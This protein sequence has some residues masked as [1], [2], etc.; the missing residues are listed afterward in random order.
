MSNRIEN[1]V[2]DGAKIIWRNFAGKPDKYNPA[3]GKRQFNLVISPDDV[4]DLVDEGWN[5]KSREPKDGEGDTLYYLP[6]NVRYDG[7]RPPKIYLIT[8]R[9]KKKTMLDEDTVAS[10]DY[11]EIINCD[12]V[13]SPYNWKMGNRTGVTAY[14]QSMYVTIKEDEF[15]DKYG[16]YS[17]DEPEEVPFH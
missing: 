17:E 9:K 4:D 10:L 15:A 3:G 13:V 5:I 1:I 2:V 7:A 11:A 14:L 16:D 6:V 8:E 12:L